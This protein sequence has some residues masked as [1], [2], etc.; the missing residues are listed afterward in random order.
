M[1][2]EN[3]NTKR[4]VMIVAEIGN[5]HN[6]DLDTAIQL[7]DAAHAAGVAHSTIPKTLVVRSHA[8]SQPPGAGMMRGRY[9]MF[10]FFQS[11]QIRT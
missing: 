5:N 8:E 2:I 1:K 6:G 7:I 10:D 4:E 11:P 9:P 3:I